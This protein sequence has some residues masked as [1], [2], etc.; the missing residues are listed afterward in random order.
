MF[1][2]TDLRQIV[3][4]IRADLHNVSP[5]C[6]I[7]VPKLLFVESYETVH[8]LVTTI[9][10][11]IAPKVGG[12][13]AIEKCFPAGSMTGAPK[14]RSVQLLEPLES[15]RDRGPYAGSLG[16]FC[17]SG[18]VD[19]SVI[20]RTIVKRGTSLELGAGGAITWLSDPKSEWEEV[21]L[22][23]NAVAEARPLGSAPQHVKAIRLES[24]TR[25]Q[26]SEGHATLATVRLAA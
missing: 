15:H 17:A 4:L 9:Q 25:N 10:S 18:T 2:I 24:E 22:K 16:Y 8:Q 5:S 26:F 19:Q 14:L 1:G 12:V 6:S 20:I 3:D 21:L 23:A 7:T 13:R 11:Q